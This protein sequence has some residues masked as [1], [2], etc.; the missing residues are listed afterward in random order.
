MLDPETRGL[1]AS[2][3]GEKGKPFQPDERMERILTDAVAIANAAARSIVWYPRADG[4]MKGI[5]VYF[6]P[7]PPEGFENNWL[8]TVPG[9]GWFVALRMYGP[10]EPWI[11]KTWRP[12]EIELVE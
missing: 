7:K 6:G 8:E 1:F 5:E 10:L 11:E 9:K 12:G 2:I 4:T 3:G